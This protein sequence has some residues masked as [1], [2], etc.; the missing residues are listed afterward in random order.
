MDANDQVLN[1]FTTRIRQLILKYKDVERENEGLRAQLA[2][3]VE[4]HER[5]ETQ[6]AQVQ[7]AY[8]SC[9]IAKMLEISDGDIEKAKERVSKILRDI[10]RCITLLNEKA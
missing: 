10:N 6:L 9:K 2:V 1:T 4:E 3:E 8:E 7:R 5:L